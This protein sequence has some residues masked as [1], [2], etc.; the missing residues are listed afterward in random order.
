MTDCISLIE[1]LRFLNEVF[2]K[3]KLMEMTKTSRYSSLVC[4][5]LSQYKPYCMKTCQLTCKTVEKTPA[6]NVGHHRNAEGDHQ[7]GKLKLH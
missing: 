7:R 1:S 3:L 5:W 2:Y 4:L 6:M